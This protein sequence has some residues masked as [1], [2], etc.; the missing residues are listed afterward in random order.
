MTT[1][2]LQTPLVNALSRLRSTFWQRRLLHWTVRAAWI[3]LLV[4]TVVMAGYIWWGWRVPWQLWLPLML[5]VGLVSMLWSV[6]PINLQRMTRR[7]DRL[8]GLRS[9]LV[10]ALEVSSA[11]TGED[12]TD[13]PVTE[14][15]IQDAVNVTTDIRDRVKLLGRSF[16]LEFNMLI[17]ILAVLGALLV[18]DALSPSLPSASAMDLPPLGTEPDAEEVIPPD[19]VLNP[20]L[21]EQL[22]N[23]SQQQIE[24]A[25]QALADALRDQGASRAISEALDQGDLGGAAEEMRRLAD[26]LG[27]LSPQAQQELGQSLQQAAE[28]IGGEAPP[29]TQ[30]LQTG[31]QALQSGN[32]PGATQALEDLAELLDTLE[33]SG[34]PDEPQSEPGEPSEQPGENGSEPGDSEGEEEGGDQQGGGDGSGEGEDGGEGDQPLLEEEEERLPIDGEPLEL[35]SDLELEDRVLQPSELDAQTD[36]DRRTSDSPFAR[37]PL[38]AP[39]DELGPDPLSYPWDKRD[40]IR[41][42]FTP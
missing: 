2:P 26:R 20:P 4:P 18:L 28:S 13:N 40:I 21:Q 19:P 15:L 14:R 29:F 17:G 6:R 16:W 10:T 12:Y 37:Q 36:D 1:A 3:A 23:L 9:Q 33:G 39:G 22:Q 5:L 42:Y 32:L 27:E 11:T 30:P 38:N 41:R 31:N 24:A 35:E 7:L 34:S 8:M 25:L